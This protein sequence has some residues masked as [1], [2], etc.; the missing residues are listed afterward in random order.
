MSNYDG[1]GSEINPGLDTASGLPTTPSDLSRDL[2]GQPFG[3]TPTALGNYDYPQLKSEDG[4]ENGFA[5][6]DSL[7]G[8]QTQNRTVSGHGYEF[9]SGIAPIDYTVHLAG[10][11]LD[12]V[13]QVIE[14]STPVVK[15][16]VSDAV[17]QISESVH[18]SI[19]TAQKNWNAP[20]N[21][22]RV[23]LNHRFNQVVGFAKQKIN[24]LATDPDVKEAVTVASRWSRTVAEKTKNFIETA[25]AATEGWVDQVFDSSYLDQSLTIA[26]ANSN[27]SEALIGVI[28]ASFEPESH[29]AQVVDAIQQSS[30]RFPDWLGDGV[31]MGRWADSLVQFVDAA[32]TSGRSGAIA[33]LSF[34][35]THINPD[36]SVSTRYELTAEE[37]NALEYAQANGVLVVVSAG[38]QNS[39]MSALGQASQD[40]NNVIAVGATESRQRADY[41]SYGAGLDFVATSQGTEGTSLATARVTGEIAK[42]WDAN[43]QINYR[44]VIQILESTANDLQQ[45]GWDVETGFGQLNTSAAINLA[46]DLSPQPL[47]GSIQMEN[48]INQDLYSA[49]FGHEGSDWSWEGAIPSER[50]NRLLEGTGTEPV[51][52]QSEPEP[53]PYQGMSADA[54]EHW[55][56][57][58]QN[59][60]YE[61]SPYQGMSANA[62]E[63]W[64]EAEQNQESE[65]SLPQDVLKYEPEAPL[66]YN[67]QVKQWQQRMRDLGYEINADG[68]Y[69]PQSADVARQFQRDKGLT[70]D[71]IVGPNTWKATLTA[72]PE[73]SDSSSFDPHEVDPQLLRAE[74]LTIDDLTQPSPADVPRT[75]DAAEIWLAT[76]EERQEILERRSVQFDD[77]FVDPANV[78]RN[79]D[80][81]EVWLA[82]PEERQEIL[83]R[84]AG[85]FSN[86]DE[87]NQTSTQAI[88]DMS[89]LARMGEA[90]ERSL[91]M[92]GDEVEAMFKE[93]IDPANLPQLLMDF[94]L[95]WGWVAIPAVGP[96]IGFIFKGQDAYELGSA[97]W[98]SMEYIRD[99]YTV[100]ENAE[101]EAD[102]D[103]AA[104]HL[105]D[106]ILTVGVDTL[107]EVLLGRAAGRGTPDDT[108]ADS[109]PDP[110]SSPQD[111]DHVPANTP[112]NDVPTN[113]ASTNTVDPDTNDTPAET[114][115]PIDLKNIRSFNDEYRASLYSPGTTPNSDNP[116]SQP[117]DA[118]EPSPDFETGTSAI[119]SS[120]ADDIT[121]EAPPTPET[122]ARSSDHTD[123]SGND[124]D[125][126]QHD[127]SGELTPE[128]I[129]A[130]QEAL[131]RDIP[132]E[133]LQD[134]DVQRALRD[135]LERQAT[136][137][138]NPY[139]GE[140]LG[141]E[142]FVDAPSNLRPNPGK[143]NE[144]RA[145]YR[146]RVSHDI[147]V[148][149][150]R[151][152]AQ[153][154]LG[155][156]Q[157]D[158][159]DNPFEYD[160]SYGQGIDDIMVAPNGNVVI[161]EYKGGES[162]LAPG[163][164]EPEW[165]E[166]QI[167]RLRDRGYE[168]YA[169]RL[170]TARQEGKLEGIALHTE[171]EHYTL[172]HSNPGQTTIIGE[173]KYELN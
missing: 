54:A 57:A 118:A 44:Q 103:T 45:S 96:A 111:A 59:Q 5:Q 35:L 120:E 99:F 17:T 163:Q 101:T 100:T 12:A 92:L 29:G 87:H 98:D 9:E 34:D 46:K 65:T 19:D 18:D 58:E 162:T 60:Q 88:A 137:P 148:Q 95:E 156:A 81:A 107:A 74:G 147:G 166:R 62:A 15:K 114:D 91:P 38:N 27:R 37:R 22:L 86:P 171:V 124:G 129:A 16:A 89:H 135:Y 21:E 80:A 121:I 24:N 20:D 143:L 168:I 84:R 160:G 75:P 63:H 70:D 23:T 136:S 165:V 132:P 164:M 130:V 69:G 141:A 14:S 126:R 31:G 149:Q 56:E 172:G 72:E 158:W 66:Q 82:S 169:D 155:Y 145:A 109:Q 150:G 48:Q 39:T 30:H 170:E 13:D 76:P 125:Q 115:R 138:E 140:P 50:L 161:V 153:Q 97:L 152:Y 90:A 106:A 32:K 10:K 105:T 94:A 3:K 52:I 112:T 151:E 79:P 102:L 53:S 2:F 173:W 134:P 1:L 43:P 123:P 154:E 7:T 40:F 41:S 51:S 71:G 67:E 157:T 78:P 47:S 85:T 68:F 127:D 83:E 49:A 146:T 73:P 93:L 104:Q 42:I 25:Q 36:G 144:A 33:N 110:S 159:W 11:A 26:S 139:T 131:G 128:E 167:R 55:I 108:S 77:P 133:R 64:S 61:P 8:L 117:D 4:N 142:Q 116:D 119:P 122:M 113:T 6:T 28:D